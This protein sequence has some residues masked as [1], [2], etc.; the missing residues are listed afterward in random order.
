[1]LANLF[2][3]HVFLNAL[4][5]QA[6][7]AQRVSMDTLKLATFW[8]GGQ[9]KGE[10]AAH[11]T[12]LLVQGATFDGTRLS[13]VNSDSP[14]TTTTVDCTL[15]WRPAE[16]VDAQLKQAGSV[17]FPLYETRNRATVLADCH[18]PC[19]A[20]DVDTWVLSGASFFAN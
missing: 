13:P 18:V 20:S 9:A 7:R 2:R 15:A 12:G 8:G 1:M 11:I 10:G 16:E 5:Q 3:P 14:T 6:A 17:A 19:A 4:R